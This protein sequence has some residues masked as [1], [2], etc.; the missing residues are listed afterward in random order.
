MDEKHK[1][2]VV[3]LKEDS[4]PVHKEEHKEEHKPEHK[5]HHKIH[6]RVKVAIMDSKT[7]PWM[8]V[9]GILALFLLIVGIMWLVQ[10][11]VQGNIATGNAAKDNM[12]FLYSDACT[13]A[14]DQMEPAIKQI[15]TDNNI[16]FT[17]SKY[18][19]AMPI[20]G[21]VLTHNNTVYNKR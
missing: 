16:G 18:F 21:Y 19:Q 13:T 2:E 4:Q 14:C 12:V 1:L 15:A 5:E 3:D 6:H 10:K 20:P 11:P 17:R 7:N 8:I 9:S